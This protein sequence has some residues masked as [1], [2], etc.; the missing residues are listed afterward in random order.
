ME[1]TA[2]LKEALRFNIEEMNLRGLKQ[3]SKFLCEQLIGLVDSPVP[4]HDSRTCSTF[5]Y[6]TIPFI[7]PFVTEP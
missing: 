1:S 2:A 4:L 5:S 6:T 7:L 3:S